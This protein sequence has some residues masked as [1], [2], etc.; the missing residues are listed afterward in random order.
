MYFLGIT[1]DRSL[2]EFNGLDVGDL[3]AGGERVDVDLDDVSKNHACLRRDI[4]SEHI[5]Y[6][7]A[8]PMLDCAGFYRLLCT[9]PGRLLGRPNS[10]RSDENRAIR[11]HYSQRIAKYRNNYAYSMV[12]R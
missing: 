10:S 1:A 9:E 5:S 6:Y 2:G 4:N 7:M 3:T 8:E 11:N 12:A